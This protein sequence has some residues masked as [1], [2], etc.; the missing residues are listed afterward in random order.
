MSRENDL[1]QRLFKLLFQNQRSE[2][3]FDKWGPNID[4]KE[5]LVLFI[6]EAV[7]VPL[8]SLFAI[9]KIDFACEVSQNPFQ[10]NFHYITNNVKLQTTYD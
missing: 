3:G 10:Y 4:I 5:L 1:Q 9:G 8:D 6:E 2:I 7:E